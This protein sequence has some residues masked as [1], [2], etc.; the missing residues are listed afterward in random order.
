MR[1]RLRT[2]RLAELLAASRL[3]Q[4]HWAIKLGLSRGHRSCLVNGRHPFPSAKT[5]DRMLETFGVP[6]ESLFA[7][8]D[9]RGDDLAFRIAIAPRYEI[10]QELG[11]GAM[12]T[13]FLAT[14]RT[15]G[16]LVAVKVVSPEAAAGIGTGALLKE[17]AWVALLQHP[18]ILPLHEAGEHAGHPYYVM[19]YVRD[20][21]LR[22]VLTRQRRFTLAEALPL[23]HGIA[24]GLS[25]AHER[26]ILHCDVKPENV[27]VQDGHCFVM[28][29]GIAR[30]LRSEALEWAGVRTELDLS[31]GTPA[32]VSPEQ[33]RGDRDVDQRSDVYSL[34]CVS[35]EMLSGR[36]P[37]G[38]TTTEEIVSRRFHEPP[39][40]LRDLAPDVSTQTA[41]VLERAMSLDP[42]LRPD[43]AGELADGLRASLNTRVIVSDAKTGE[44]PRGR[45]HDD[46]HRHSPR[47]RS[48][49]RVSMSGF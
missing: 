4:N 10:M 48:M 37:F 23:I 34:A 36:T 6:L 27:L 41:F 8:D 14:D 12:G 31:A 49:P 11:Q 19:P 28:D 25:H 29:F 42:T 22:A 5:R 17:I 46:A 35:F 43:S 3:S 47:R 16:R 20:G 30:K 7:V 45:A 24:R 13:V 26:Q 18:N 40:A 38:G 1:L 44:L 32:Y 15:L 33:A 2:D 21:S 39:P 9:G